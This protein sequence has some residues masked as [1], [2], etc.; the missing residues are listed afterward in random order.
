VGTCGQL[1]GPYALAGS[2]MVLMHLV[3]RNKK[4]A[5]T[6]SPSARLFL[7]IG[8][9]PS[10]RFL[11]LDDTITLLYMYMYVHVLMCRS[12]ASLPSAFWRWPA[13][14]C[15][16][17]PNSVCGL[18]NLQVCAAHLPSSVPLSF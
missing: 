15:R 13:A 11:A 7:Q 9:L 12:G 8:S 16:R 17:S 4:D 3:R 18:A 5:A 14:S 10:I 2:C 6:P 1:Y